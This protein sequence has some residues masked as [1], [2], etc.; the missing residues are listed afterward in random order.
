M[1]IVVLKFGGTSVG[2]IAKIKK[3]AEIIKQYRKK[4]FSVI[5][6]DNLS[7]NGSSINIKKLKANKKF[8]L[9]FRKIWKCRVIFYVN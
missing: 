1:K 2:T 5:G 6:I 4:K 8:K 7:R 3:V 9:A